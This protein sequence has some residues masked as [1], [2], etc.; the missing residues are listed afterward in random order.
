MNVFRVSSRNDCD[1]DV[2]ACKQMLTLAESSVQ[3][4]VLM[5]RIHEGIDFE[6][7]AK[8]LLDLLVG[9]ASKRN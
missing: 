1:E 5:K 2:G 3:D 6:L 8:L 4:L 7:D 9:S